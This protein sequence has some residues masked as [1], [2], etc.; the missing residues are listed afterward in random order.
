M[1][2]S[3]S[4]FSGAAAE[5]IVRIIGIFNAFGLEDLSV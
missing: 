1:M 2:T 5:A 4:N 3:H